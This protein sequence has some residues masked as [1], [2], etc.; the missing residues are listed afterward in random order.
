MTTLTTLTTVTTMTTMEPLTI[1]D[2]FLAMRTR[3]HRA[4][5][6]SLV[7]HALLA[8]GLAAVHGSRAV[9]PRIVEVTWLE[10]PVGAQPAPVI[11]RIGKP[12]PAKV[13]PRPVEAAER[14]LPTPTPS[15]PGAESSWRS[16]RP[17]AT[18]SPVSCRSRRWERAP[19]NCWPVPRPGART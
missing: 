1:H 6:I 18:T 14:P 2:D 13:A 16:W 12:T 5:A 17:R 4:L 3:F 9:L 11:T 19:A 7:V 10:A 15:P 8:V